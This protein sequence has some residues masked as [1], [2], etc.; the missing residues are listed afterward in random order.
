MFYPGKTAYKRAAGCG[1]WGRRTAGG[2][3]THT[4]YQL[5]Y[6]A[7]SSAWN[8]LHPTPG[9]TYLLLPGEQYKLES[10]Q[11]PD[12]AYVQGWHDGW[13]AAAS[14]G[15][16][17]S[18]GMPVA[19]DTRPALAR[20]HRTVGG[21]G[22]HGA[23]QAETI[24][25]L[26]FSA[27][28]P[29]V[30]ALDTS[31]GTLVNMGDWPVQGGYAVAGDGQTVCLN[32]VC[33]LNMGHAYALYG[34]LGIGPH[35][36]PVSTNAT[37]HAALTLPAAKTAAGCGRS[38]PKLP[39][40]YVAALQA[41]GQQV[42]AAEEAAKTAQGSA[43]VPGPFETPFAGVFHNFP[44]PQVMFDDAAAMMQDA[45]YDPYADGHGTIYDEEMRAFQELQSNQWQR[46]AWAE[47]QAGI[48]AQPMVA[49]AVANEVKQE[50]DVPKKDATK[51][52]SGMY[53]PTGTPLPPVAATYGQ[54]TRYV[55][56]SG[57]SRPSGLTF[58][59]R[60]AAGANLDPAKVAIVERGIWPAFSNN[61][62]DEIDWTQLDVGPYQV[63]VTNE[64]L[65]VS[66]LRLPTNMVES[67][68]IANALHALPITPVVSDARWHASDRATAFGNGFG[69]AAAINDP[70]QVI[71]WNEK[72]PPAGQFSDGFWKET[73]IVPGLVERGKGALAQYGGR[74]TTAVDSAMWQEGKPGGHDEHYKDYSNTP[75][76]MGRIA[77]KN[78][79]QVDLLDELAAGCELG[80][81]I[82][83]WLVAKFRG[84]AV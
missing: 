8:K 62:T 15:S 31:N 19:F 49:P 28:G 77:L 59:R 40:S 84:G 12:P 37:G 65:A 80:G 1:N 36:G 45:F 6:Q 44:P 68:E 41:Q 9:H 74:K 67:I 64:P 75:T 83:A 81:P 66:G 14:A 2:A 32:D 78:G 29:C 60:H 82:P 3:S 25:V 27:D 71:G 76:Y 70:A 34:D 61:E 63:M 22:T 7:G 72:H 11:N 53:L 13:A 52:A 23:H 5:G 18:P 73:V 4:M 38:R 57:G 26:Y 20:S 10:P 46:M 50:H 21:P 79:A 17:H 33:G 30:C 55:Q 56:G 48:A 16:T 69:G 35:L 58:P 51:K 39:A 42:L 47:Q 24:L 43:R 54:R